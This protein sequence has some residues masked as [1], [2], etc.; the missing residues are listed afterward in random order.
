[1]SWMSRLVVLAGWLVLVSG[2]PVAADAVKA[3]VYK[4]PTCGCCEGYVRFLREHGYEVTIHDVENM[5]GV[6]RMLG[7]QPELGS[8]HT[9]MIGGYVVE[10]HVP[11]E[12]LER[13]LAEKPAIKGI[14]LPGM[15]SGVPGMDGPRP[16]K[17][18]VYTLE[19]QPRVYDER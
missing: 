12:V 10:G 5:D 18:T 17:V 4:S 14:S 19:D 11:L 8:C 2:L 15:P 9:S 1:M 3:T 7:V 16:D 6:K 13:L